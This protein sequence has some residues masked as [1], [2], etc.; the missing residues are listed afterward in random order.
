MAAA[1]QLLITLKGLPLAY[2]KDMQESRSRSSTVAD[3]AARMLEVATGFMQAVEFNLPRMEQAASS[4]YMN[5]MAAATYLA[6]KGVPF[7]RAHE[8]VGRAVRLGMEKGCELEAIPLGEL[9]E[10]SEAFGEDFAASV[11]LE[12]TLDCHD[13]TGGT[14][15]ARVAA[16][17]DAMD[18]RLKAA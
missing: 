14:A 12:K 2:S 1:T 13:V 7:R 8:F 5:A 6:N 17:L 16:A 15:R 3:T 11:T 10:I 18:A 4:G 9:R